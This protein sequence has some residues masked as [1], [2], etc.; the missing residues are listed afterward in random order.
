MAPATDE[1]LVP[2]DTGDTQ[3]SD[4]QRSKD[5]AAQ[6][7]AD[8]DEPEAPTP[9][10]VPDP[11]PPP[12]TDAVKEPEPVEQKSDVPGFTKDAKG[13]YHRPDGTVASK[14]EVEKARAAVPPPVETPPAAPEAPKPEEPAVEPLQWLAYGKPVEIPGAQYKPGHGVFI[15][16]ASVPALRQAWARGHERYPTVVNENAELREA[17][18]QTFTRREAEANAVIEV[19]GSFLSSEQAFQQFLEQAQQAPGLALREIRAALKEKQVELGAQVKEPAAHLVTPQVDP[20][21]VAEALTDELEETFRSPEFRGRFT[22]KEQRDLVDQVFRRAA[23]YLTRVDRDYPE[24]G[25]K[26]GDLVVNREA[27]FADLMYEAQRGRPASPPSAPAS[28]SP[29]APAAQPK[30][31]APPPPPPPSAV[32]R[33]TTTAAPK[34]TGAKAGIPTTS[35]KA[36]AD[37]LLADDD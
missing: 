32:G 18:Q 16:D 34:A 14:D 25:I 8:D 10:V 4:Q 3:V 33:S 11:E 21:E 27:L 35:L 19:L 17:L 29:V 36:T 24:A 5:V 30:A 13:R 22:P 15:P 7:F 9:A 20:G 6:L 28:A 37:W 2:L 12:Q 31:A 23:A 26:S 1:G